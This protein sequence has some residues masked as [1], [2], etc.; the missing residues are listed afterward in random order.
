SDD[1]LAFTQQTTVTEAGTYLLRVTQRMTGCSRVDN[2][3]VRRDVAVPILSFPVT[4]IPCEEAASPLAVMPDQ[5]GDYVYAWMGP[6]IVAGAATDT[7]RINGVGTY[8]V[9]VTNLDNGCPVS[10][11]VSVSRLP[12]PPFPL[13]P[14]TSLTC[15]TDT[16][17]LIAT[18]AEPCQGCNFRWTRNG[19][20][21]VGET[22]SIL[23]VAE[24]G[25]Y[26]IIVFN[27]FGLRGTAVGSVIDSRVLPVA[28]AGPDR[29]LTCRVTDVLLGNPAPEPDFPFAYQW[30]DAMGLALP[31]ATNDSL[32]V[33]NGIF[34]QLRTTNLFSGCV[35]LD[36]VR[37]TYDTLLPVADAGTPRL[38][39]CNNKR[40]TLDGI[41]SSLGDRYVYA[42]AGGPTDLCLEGGNTLNPIVRCG[43]E[44]RL[45]VQDTVNGCSAAASVLVENDDELPAV[46][47]LRDTMIDCTADTV[48]LVGRPVGEPGRTFRWERLLS[49]GNEIMA[50]E[51]PG[52]IAVTDAGEFRFTVENTL[53]GC[54]N[55]FTVAVAADLRRPL[56]EAGPV[57]TFYCELDSLQL[58]GMGATTTGR[59]AIFAWE[60][61]TGFFV[62]DAT[63]EEAM[64]FQPDVYYFTVTDPGNGC[65]TTDSVLIARDVEA[66]LAL[67]GNDTS[68]TCVRRE[69]QLAGDWR[70]L[71]GQATFQWTTRDGRILGG[72]QT[73]SP[74][75]DT[76]G[77]YQLNV[78]DPVNDCSAA[79]IVRVREDTIPPRGMVSLPQGDQLDC[80]RSSLVL[81]G[82]GNRAGLRFLWSGP[83]GPLGE[84]REQ[85]V[86][87]AGD[88]RLVVENIRNGCRDTVGTTVEGNFVLPVAPIMPAPPLTCLRQTVRLLP[89]TGAAS[90]FYEYTW[91]D[92]GGTNLGE[93]DTLL[94]GSRGTYRLVA[95]DFR[96]GC[97]DTAALFVDANLT[98]PVVQLAE[99]LVLN[100]NRSFTTIDGM[101]SSRGSNFVVDWDSPNNSAV[102]SGDPYQVRGS[103]PGFY[104]LTVTNRENGC[105]TTDSVELR[106][107][108]LAVDDLQIEVDQPACPEDPTGSVMVLGVDGGQ[109][110][111]RYRLDGGLLTDR[112]I[113][114]GLPPGRY[115]L[116]AVGADGCSTATDFV[117]NPGQP[118]FVDLLEDT[119]VRLGD[120]I[121]LDFQT[122]LTRWDSLVWTSSGP[123]PELT[124]AG[125]ITVRPLA[126]QGYRL[127]VVG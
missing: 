80:N 47:P 79:D 100:C 29:I 33:S 16:I 43:G 114:E 116:A 123:L 36:T 107:S 68:L 5:E 75:V 18:F 30:L 55:D 61:A 101:G 121:A 14:D 24:T 9:T 85:R 42:W 72:S 49:S 97:R 57:D 22:D 90:P 37:I 39:D 40:R 106:Q 64:I 127:L 99:P 111:F 115:A 44:Y 4:E 118:V 58:R 20:P 78:T 25:E 76:V 6:A 104:F 31:G 66:P 96:N 15:E 2:V 38:L 105:V 28:N 56:A 113:Y 92:E 59:P 71:S 81:R 48:R 1:T 94:V 87:V 45:T 7:V 50:E 122:N 17:R 69:L 62:N 3:I 13:L 103:V 32:R 84:G 60:S 110:P 52:V 126:S 46:I 93:N 98:A 95:R 11:D 67:A 108:A 83:S 119:I 19:V 112:L 27:S 102:A 54:E 8:G 23:P 41:R 109:G 63:R 125:P 12:C 21:L 10:A 124:S 117:I 34:Y 82:S 65:V 88:Y 51:A 26:E 77:R 74:L 35:D 86:N 89:E 91:L 53:T 120:S 73:L 70:S